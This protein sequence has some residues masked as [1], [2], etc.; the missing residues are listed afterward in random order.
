MDSRPRRRNEALDPPLLPR[1]RL[2]LPLRIRPGRLDLTT[3]CEVVQ[4]SIGCSGELKQPLAM[5]AS[6]NAAA[7]ASNTELFE[8]P[9]HILAFDHASEKARF[10]IGVFLVK[11]D[12]SSRIP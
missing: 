8:N 6:E 1:A 11:G 9:A 12:D 3:A 2:M 10:V 5:G 4:T 7:A